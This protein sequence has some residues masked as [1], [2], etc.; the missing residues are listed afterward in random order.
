MAYRLI[1]DTPVVV[2]TELSRLLWMAHGLL[3]S[4]PK[5]ITQERD[6][7]LWMAYGLR[8]L[9]PVGTKE[10]SPKLLWIAYG[11]LSL[12]PS[13]TGSTVSVTLWM[14]C[15][16]QK[17]LRKEN[18]VIAGG[19]LFISIRRRFSV[20]HS[21]LQI[22][23]SKLL[24]NLWILIMMLFSSRLYPSTPSLCRSMCRY[25]SA[26]DNLLMTSSVPQINASLQ[27]SYF[28]NPPSRFPED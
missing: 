1:P 28:G 5:V 25:V 8:P 9:T 10:S 15:R 11:L 18:P 7:K 26:G 6:E 3:P 21:D 27:D 24:H 20:K 23:L 13:P 19:I 14:A 17:N 2:V 22:C 16:K 4:T 12:T